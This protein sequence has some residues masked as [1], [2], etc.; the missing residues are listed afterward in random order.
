LIP[1]R[2]SIVALL[3][4][5]ADTQ[6]ADAALLY[7]Y[8]PADATF[9]ACALADDASGQPAPDAAHLPS[10]VARRLEDLDKPIVIEGA[11]AQE[12]LA[13][14]LPQG[15]ATCLLM[16]VGVQ[17]NR[18]LFVYL[19]WHKSRPDHDHQKVSQ[20]AK[21]LKLIISKW[22]E[23]NEASALMAEVARLQLELADSKIAE[24]T[25]GLIPRDDLRQ[26]V[27]PDAINQ[28][29]G[30]VLQSCEDSTV[31]AKR[32]EDLKAELVSRERIAVAKGI[33][34]KKHGIAEQEAYLRLQGASRKARIPLGD[35]A[36][37]VVVAQKSKRE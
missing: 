23:E 35:L 18:T 17:T 36:E 20:L 37:Q 34:Q 31:L 6:E 7:E 21:G 10:E 16:P 33:L 32:V 27:F 24:R 14:A 5:I 2:R 3:K 4:L 12:E 26:V 13:S 9:R 28:H 22:N 8:Y 29:I 1:L 15:F 19:G 11:T 30:L 25:A